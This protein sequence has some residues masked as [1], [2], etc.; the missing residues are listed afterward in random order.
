MKRQKMAPQARGYPAMVFNKV[1]HVIDRE[2]LREAYHQPQKSSAPGMDH[3]TAQQYAARLD[4]HLR[5]LHERRRDHR[6]EA[7]PGERVWSEQADGQQRPRG[8]PCCE[9]QSVQRAVVRILEAIFEQDVHAFSHGVR[10]GPSP[11]QARHERREQGR[12]LHSTWRVDADGSGFFDTVDWSPLR[13]FLQQRGRDGGIRRLMG[14][15]LHAGVL[16]AGAL[17]PPDKGPPQGGGRSPML[18]NVFVHPVLDA[19]CVKDVRPRRQ[20]PCL[21]M[22]FAD[23]LIIGCE[24]AAEA[25]RILDV[26]PKRLP[27]FRRTMPPEKTARL[28]CKRPP[29]RHQ[30][31]GGTGTFDFLGFPH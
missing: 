30:S 12:T 21:L 10:Q 31:A 20:G 19:W 1:L 24:H 26:L 25:R 14:T 7:P 3:V 23:A 13:E 8:K 2:C 5:D 28:A 17:R 4:E 16:E 15:W 6:S 22:R 9:D 11:Q 27:R 18:A 29:S